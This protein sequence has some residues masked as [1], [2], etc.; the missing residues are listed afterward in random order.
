MNMVYQLGFGVFLISYDVAN[1]PIKELY[2]PL[3]TGCPLSLIP[4]TCSC[5]EVHF[6]LKYILLV[7]L[8]RTALVSLTSSNSGEGGAVEGG[9]FS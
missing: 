1:S 3:G 4:Y 5:G 8:G 7:H 6:S 2:M 9:A